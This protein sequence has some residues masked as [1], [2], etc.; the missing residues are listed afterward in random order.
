M[1]GW[2]RRRKTT[3]AQTLMRGLATAGP[4]FVSGLPLSQPA[5]MPKGSPN[6]VEGCPDRPPRPAVHSV[7]LSGCRVL[8]SVEW[9]AAQAV[10]SS[11]GMIAMAIAQANAAISRAMATVT[12]LAG[13]PA[14]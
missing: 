1:H 5:R 12:M 14:R 7:T 4:W 11:G 3:V 6:H 2:T 9:L 13:L 8:L 10:G